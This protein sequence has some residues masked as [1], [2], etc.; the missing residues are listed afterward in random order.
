MNINRIQNPYTK[1]DERYSDE[2]R[3]LLKFK[4]TVNGL[5]K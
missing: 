5:Q 4:S 1:V 2:N 3:L